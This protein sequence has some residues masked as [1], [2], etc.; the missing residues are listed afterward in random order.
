MLRKRL[1]FCLMP[2][3]LGLAL[4]IIWLVGAQPAP[5]AVSSR[6]CVVGP[7]SGAIAADETWCIEDAPHVVNGA[8][9]INAGIALTVEAGVEVRFAGV[10][11]DV[12]GSL[13]AEGTDTQP[14]TFTSDAATPAPD[15]WSRIQMNGGAVVRMDYCDLGYAGGSNANSALEMYASDVVIDHC[16]IHDNAGTVGAV[17]ML[18]VGIAPAIKNTRFEDNTG[19]PIYQ[20]NMDMA[21]THQNLTFSGNTTDAIYMARGNSGNNISR[22]VIW[23]G[24]ELNG[25]PII[26]ENIYIDA[27]GW[28]TLTAGTTLRL[29]PTSMLEVY[30]GGHLSAAGNGTWPVTITSLDSSST[31]SRLQFDAGSHVSLEYCDISRVSS[32]QQN[33]LYVVGSDVVIDHCNI[34]DNFS[35]LAV[36]HLVSQGS[37]PTIRNTTIQNNSGYAIYQFLD[38]AATYE[39][40][41]LS[42]NTTDAVYIYPAGTYGQKIYRPVTWDGPQ[43]NGSPFIAENFTIDP[44]GWLTLTAGTTL[45]LTSGAG[46]GVQNEGHLTAAGTESQPVIIT[47]LDVGS[48]MSRLQFDAGSHVSLEYCDISRV[49]SSQQNSLS[50]SSSDVVIDHCIIH[51][52]FSTVAV[53]RLNNA[54]LSPTIKNTIIE[55]STGYPIYQNHIDMTPTYQNLTFSGNTTDAIYIYPGVPNGYISRPITWDSS[56]LNGSPFV[57]EYITVVNGGW[58]TLTAG[59]TISMTSSAGIH[60]SGGGY[61]NV[62]GT[63][64]QPVTITS[65]N[66]SS[67]MHRLQIDSGSHVFLEYCDISRV[68]NTEYYSLE[69]S[70]SDVLIDHCNIHDNF[71]NQGAVRINGVGLSPT[72]Q[73]TV[74][75]NNVGYAIYHQQA[76]MAPI[77]RSLTLSGNGTNAI[78]SPGGSLGTSRYW[79]YG[80]A[81]APVQM[82]SSLTVPSTLY[83]SLEPGTLMQFASD[84]S[85][86]VNGSLYLLGTPTQGITL[87]SVLGTPGTWRGVYI[88]SSGRAILNYCE[89]ANGGQSSQALLYTA[90]KNVSVLNCQIHH[91]ANEGV[92]IAN[93]AQ[94][95]FSYNQIFSNNFGMRNNTPATVVDAR[96]N[97]WGDASGPLHVILN[98]SGLGNAVSDGILFDPWLDSPEYSEEPPANEVVI[99][100][101]GPKRVSPGQTVNYAIWYSNL[102]M[103]TVEEAVLVLAVPFN[104]QMIDSTGGGIEWPQRH[105]VYW[106]LGDLEPGESGSLSVRIRYRW[107]IPDLTVDAAQAMMVGVNLPHPPL[108]VEDYLNYE[109]LFTVDETPLSQAEFDAERAAL[110]DLDT[111]YNQL[112]ARG[113]AGEVYYS[114]EMN[115]S[116]TAIQAVFTTEDARSMAYLYREGAEAMAYIFNRDS[117]IVMLPGGSITMTLPSAGIPDEGNWPIETSLLSVEGD[118]SDYECLFNCAFEN[119]GMSLLGEFLD[120]LGVVQNITACTIYIATGDAGARNDCLTGMLDLFPGAGTLLAALDCYQDF[121][122]DPN[123]CKCT[124]DKWGPEKVM[125]VD[126]CTRTPCNKDRGMYEPSQMESFFCPFCQMCMSGVGGSSSP[127]DHCRACNEGPPDECQPSGLF[128]LS[129]PSQAANGGPAGDCR[130]NCILIPRDPNALYGPEGDL[131][132]GQWVTYTITFENEGAGRAYGVYILDELSEYFDE[133]TLVLNNPGTYLA[134]ARTILWSVGELGPK[135]DPDS[136]GSLSFRVQLKAGLPGGTIIANQAVVHFPSAPEVTPTNMWINIIQPVSA[137]PQKVET[138]Y[139]Q[140]IAITLQGMDVGGAPL[141]YQVEKP[142]L[143]GELSGSAPAL[144]YTPA[145]NFTGLD[146]FTFVVSNGIT[147]SRPAEVQILVHPSAAD[148][149]RPEVT[150]TLPADNETDVYYRTTAILTDTIGPVYAPFLTIKFTEAISQTSLTTGAI[151]LVDE[152]EHPVSVRLVYNARTY[153]VTIVPT[154]PL[155]NFT[156]YTV[157]INTTIRDLMGNTLEAVFT[158]VFQTADLYQYVYVPLIFRR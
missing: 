56:Q 4:V 119:V 142:P 84:T 110:P 82:L 92:K 140:P 60:I 117:M 81:G 47:S 30:G 154:E 129:Y 105:H 148:T 77:Y 69:I 98:P 46:I 134:P 61:F 118:L 87:T 115:T 131:T 150:W 75:Q 146:S 88:N 71:S 31:M 78:V 85:L 16:T 121:K 101:A 33:S 51:D 45:R 39:N 79:Q 20:T 130:K 43:L 96:N 65:L 18:S 34:H 95:V 26:A 102:T 41:T 63:G 144:T 29:N 14:I 6:N 107:G 133:S 2:V 155:K 57:A 44:S 48:T 151:T 70:G 13:I 128:N 158:W 59:T 104:A 147:E 100:L 64:S 136:K 37:S 156:W 10:G 112:L 153:E 40:L 11:M 74:I 27:S 3:S 1:S 97:W 93:N 120:A 116:Q 99:D 35:T 25:S 72:I 24:G 149:T 127:W 109:P 80:Q 50:I 55:D 103:T 114:L 42:G 94:P 135:G 12:S 141:T 113:F 106:K 9:T 126:S 68:V 32:S 145:E 91:S 49:G 122:A 125:G 111:L 7:H 138:T 38:L 157:T 5:A 52:N 22:P 58:L 90:S 21:P 8:V 73:N 19:Y 15:D 139:I 53:I 124:D 67:T 137:W 23:D 123:S 83:L 86:T 36:I 108:L 17:R 66:S 143:F 54:G 89:L 62:T 76:D 132:P 152:D 28:L